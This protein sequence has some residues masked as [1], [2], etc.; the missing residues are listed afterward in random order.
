MRAFNGDKRY[1]NLSD[2]FKKRFGKKVFK[3]PLDGG[4]TCPNKD[5][6]K[7]TGGCIYCSPSGSGD[8]TAGRDVDLKTQFDTI[9]KKML[10]KWSDA[11]TMPYFQA[12]TNTYAPV[13]TLKPMFEAALHFDESVVGIAIAT[14]CDALGE[15]VIELLDTLNKVKP[16][17][18]E[19]G[20]QTIHEESAAFINRGH[21][22]QCFDEAV[23]AVRKKGIE[24]V[25]H[26]ING[27]PGETDADMLET[28]DHL[29]MLDIQGLKIHMLHVMEQTA[30]AKVYREKPFHM[31]T[32]EDYTRITVKQIEKLNPDVVI[33]RLS[34]D[35]P[36]DMLIAPEWTLKK[37][38][39]MNEID[40]LLRKKD[41]HQGI[42]FNK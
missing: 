9:K 26:I 24:V 37:L 17:Q 14:R 33:H 18:L 6:S 34:G 38:V 35:A 3:V 12:N 31:L 7:G 32:L 30:L 28:I 40:K 8:F 13:E 11:Y 29:N 21:D 1:N 4:F 36:K 16:V 10:N 25:V 20:L 23:K 15:D 41:T 19:I 39:V 2:S 42:Y 22:L 5:G 27:L